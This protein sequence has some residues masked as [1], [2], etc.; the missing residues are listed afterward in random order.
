MA[1]FTHKNLIA[2]FYTTGSV[3]GLPILYFKLS[4]KD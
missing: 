2:D 3:L 4:F 1:V